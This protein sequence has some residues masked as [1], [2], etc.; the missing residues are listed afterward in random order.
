MPDILQDKLEVKLQDDIFVFR[1]PTYLDE[2]KLGMK[3]RDIRRELGL[4]IGGD[5]SG[6][7]DGLDNQTFF[8][9]Q[10]AA[11]F[12]LLLVQSSVQWPWSAGPEGKP[13]VDFHKWPSDKVGDAIA[14]GA[15]FAG[16]LTTF[17][18]GGNT[19]GNAA[20]SEAMASQ[21]NSGEKPV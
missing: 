3:E 9:V 1:I 8:M 12:E 7:P 19:D 17:R 10:T 11:R 18:S 15:L 16:E 4:E 21:S 14:V 5:Q 6:N 20:S 2:I 13:V